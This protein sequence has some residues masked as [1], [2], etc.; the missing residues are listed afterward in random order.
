M[1]KKLLLFIL[2]LTA[3]L[4]FAEEG[5]ISPETYA[6]NEADLLDYTDVPPPPKPDVTSADKP[7]KIKKHLD[8]GHSQVQKVDYGQPERQQRGSEILSGPLVL[9]SF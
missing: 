8:G 1:I 2:L 4:A 3:P 6:V 5:Y 7:Q 9:L